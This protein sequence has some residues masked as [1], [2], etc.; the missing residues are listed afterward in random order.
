MPGVPVELIART[1]H[2]RRRLGRPVT[3]AVE[4]VDVTERVSGFE[5]ELWSSISST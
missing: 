1:R 4:G 5:N 2:H 3:C